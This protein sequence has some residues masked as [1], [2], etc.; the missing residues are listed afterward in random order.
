MYFSKKSGI[1]YGNGYGNL[2]ILKQKISPLYRDEI[3][4][5]EQVELNDVRQDVI[6][7]S[8]GTYVIVLD[9]GYFIYEDTAPDSIVMFYNYQKIHV[10]DSDDLRIFLLTKKVEE[11]KDVPRRKW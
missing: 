6:D 1:L 5:A 9:T 2:Q 3:W 10:T 11:T 7:G 4:E 8:Q